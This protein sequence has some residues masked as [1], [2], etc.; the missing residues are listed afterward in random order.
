MSYELNYQLAKNNPNQFWAE[1]AKKIDWFKQPQ[2]VLSKN[3]DGVDSWFA[4]AELNTSY[5]ALDYQIKQGLGNQTAIIYDSPVT[6]TCCKISYNTLLQRV[7]KFA[8][9]LSDQGVEKGDRVLIYMP[10]IPEAVVA[11]LATARLGAIHSVVFGGFAAHELAIRIDDAEPKAIVTASCGIEIDKIIPYKPIVDRSIQEARFKPSTCIVYQRSQCVANLNNAIDIDWK[12]QEAVAKSHPPVCVNASDPLYI[13]YTS[14]TTGTPKGIVRDNG[15][16]AVAMKYSMET[17]YG[18]KQGDVFWAASDVGWV[19]GH[20]Y[21]VYGPLMSG[22][23]TVLYEGKPVKTPD[24]GAFWRVCDDHKVNILFSAPTAFRAIRKEDPTAEHYSKFNLSQL[25][26]LYLAGERLDPST[27]HWLKKVTNKPVI[28]HWWQTETGWPIAGIPAGLEIFKEQEG[29]AGLPIPGFQVEIL[30]A[31]GQ[32]C[33]P[34]QEGTIAIKLP[35]PPGCLTTVWN[36]PQRFK[37]GYLDS[38]K[39]YYV[40]GD[41]GFMDNN[42]YLYIMG[43]TDDV[44]NVAGHRLSTGEME[45]VIAAHTAVAEC[46]VVGIHCPIKGQVPFALV[47]LKNGLKYLDSYDKE[48]KHLI[49]EQIGAIASLKEICVAA[50]LP[51]TRSGKVLRKVMRQM[52]DGVTYQVPST[53]ED[54]D[55]ISELQAQFSQRTLTN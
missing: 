36:N 46:A 47:V 8:T 50:R 5:L 31:D 17:V 19:V 2:E 4:G 43:R 27:Y 1:Q 12:A 18:A 44:I 38:F 34:N 48:L 37:A 33:E 6:N 32:H 14:G 55:V 45:D 39:G 28:D 30:A 40:T 10:M 11:M 20:S 35:L 51:K 52:I 15:G 42:N 29:S 13:L 23:T 3:E 22:C 25:K 49:R 41:G 21:I 53:I 16:H 24:A 54:A 26:R 7:E 9:V